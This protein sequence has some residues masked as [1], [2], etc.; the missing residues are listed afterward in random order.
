M[1]VR[2]R[3][4][5][6]TPKRYGPPNHGGEGRIDWFGSPYDLFNR[7]ELQQNR[8]PQTREALGNRGMSLLGGRQ[9]CLGLGLV[10]ESIW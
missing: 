2:W 4:S 1:P 8:Q 9:S 5:A 6:A 3:V 7:F 10:T